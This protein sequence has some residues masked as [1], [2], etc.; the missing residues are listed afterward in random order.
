L[1]YN[2]VSKES[3]VG[4]QTTSARKTT[5]ISLVSYVNNLD[6]PNDLDQYHK[7]FDTHEEDRCS[8]GSIND[9]T[10]NGEGSE[11]DHTHDSDVADEI[12]YCKKENTVQI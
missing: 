6:Y 7:P 9:D 11:R 3:A 10:E 8:V 1:N 4:Y 12:Q 5:G 2:L